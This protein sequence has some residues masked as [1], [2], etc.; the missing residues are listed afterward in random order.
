VRGGDVQ[1]DEL[2]GARL[3]VASGEFDRVAGVAKADEV[4]PLHDAPVAHIETG[5]DALA[6]H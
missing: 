5:D 4:D 1:K 6:E 3:V 2:V